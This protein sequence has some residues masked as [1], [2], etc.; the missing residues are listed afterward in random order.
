V[1]DATHTAASL[2][3]AQG[4]DQWVV[5]QILGHS[6]IS[7]ASK[8]AHVMPPVMTDAA[9]RIGKALW[10]PAAKPTATRTAT[11]KSSR[12]RG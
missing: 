12:S 4:V 2:L 10:G 1:H 9:D 6:Q 8:Y 7:M 5:M 11:R 3:L